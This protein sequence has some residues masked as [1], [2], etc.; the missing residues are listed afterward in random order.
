M[1]S[2]MID[3]SENKKSSVDLYNCVAD[4]YQ[5]YSELRRG[6]LSS[7]DDIVCKTAGRRKRYMDVGAGDGRRSINIARRVDAEEILLLDNSDKML[8]KAP[9]NGTIRKKIASI[10][11]YCDT[12]KFDLITCLWNVFGHI[13]GDKYR[14]NALVNICSMLEDDGLAVIDVNNRYNVSHYGFKALLKNVWNDLTHAPRRGIFPLDLNG[15][16]SEVYIH[17]PFELD[18]S[19]EKCGLRVRKK[20]YLNY[21]DGSIVKTYLSGQIVYIFEKI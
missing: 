2:I 17:N 21:K 10:T 15:C 1:V 7:V 18:R 13:E 4:S 11:N 6:Y 14:Y 5:A 9:K 20:Y 19:T 16:L 8:A 3:N 12:R